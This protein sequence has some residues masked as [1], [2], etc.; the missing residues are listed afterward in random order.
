ML[1]MQLKCLLW[2]C[3]RVEST[4]S[5][6][7]ARSDWRATRGTRM[8]H[9]ITAARADSRAELS[10]GNSDDFLLRLKLGSIRIKSCRSCNTEQPHSLTR[11][12]RH[13]ANLRLL[14]PDYHFGLNQQNG[15][16][17]HTP[18]TRNMTLFSYV[19]G[20]AGFGLAARLWQLGI[21][22]RNLADSSL[23]LLLSPFFG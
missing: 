9:K 3:Q 15:L 18:D 13:F 10:L 7:H 20:G 8:P 21:M 4:L 14:L 19:L 6:G 22:K 23:S 11:Y 17:P 12:S 5:A 2:L 1:K 16:I